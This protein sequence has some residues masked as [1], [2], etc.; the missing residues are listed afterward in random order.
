MK[1]KYFFIISLLFLN[2]AVAQDV[3]TLTGSTSG[4]LD[5]TGTAALFNN[6]WGMVTETDGNVYVAD[7]LNHKIRKITPAGVV[8]TFAGSTQGYQDANGTS[9]KFYRPNGLAIDASG[10]IYVADSYNHK[11]RKITP[12]GDVTTVAGSAQGYVNGNGTAA[13]FN[14]PQGIAIDS[15]GNL[16]VVDAS[17]YAIRKITP[18]ADVTVFAGGGTYGFNDGTGSA[19]KFNVIKAIAIDTATNDM[20]VTDGH[21]IRKITSAAVVT[22]FAGATTNGLVNGTLSAARFNWPEGIA[23][24]A[25]GDIYIAD[26][27]NCVIRKITAAGVVSS[28]AGNTNGIAGSANGTG[29]AS[30]FYAPKGICLDASRNIYIADSHYGK[31]RKIE[32]SSLSVDDFNLTKIAFYPNPV[33]DVLKI[34]AETDIQNI[35][36]TDVNGKEV[37]N[38]KCSSKAVEIN[39]SS[40]E[41][42]IYFLR[43]SSNDSSSKVYKIIKK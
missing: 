30:S 13:R 21:R 20:Y 19:A 17:N 34:D 28:L 15:A 25:N 8:T 2:F 16:F 18:T 37:F 29:A 36:I 38:Q 35:Q 12:S 43:T 7:E 14:F 32:M 33:M 9:A 5:G 42:G 41:T 11:I 39:C 22:A 23:V 1:T 27:I 4:F 31:I 3:S 40:F 26:T 24:D 6:P 10:N